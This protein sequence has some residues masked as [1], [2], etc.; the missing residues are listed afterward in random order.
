M[1]AKGFF[2][3]TRRHRRTARVAE[4]IKARQGE[5]IRERRYGGRGLQPSPG[6]VVVTVRRGQ[7][8][9]VFPAQLEAVI[10]AGY[11]PPHPLPH[12]CGPGVFFERT[13]ELP[14]VEVTAFPSGTEFVEGFGD[15][16]PE[17]HTGIVVDI[18]T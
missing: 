15:F 7:L 16:V 18:S 12:R 3:A 17:G 9:D 8:N 6:R 13:D 10:A 14:R 2:G 5:I 4:L 11:E 1:G